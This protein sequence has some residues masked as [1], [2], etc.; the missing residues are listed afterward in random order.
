MI[1]LNTYHISKQTYRNSKIKKIKNIIKK[2]KINS[3][4]QQNTL[5]KHKIYY[6]AYIFT[7]VI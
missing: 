1:K 2:E 5:R 7:S 3:H 4:K 6:S